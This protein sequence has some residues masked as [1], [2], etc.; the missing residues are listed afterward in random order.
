M[1][2]KHRVHIGCRQVARNA[3]ALARKM[4]SLT[5]A[6]RRMKD[7]K[8]FD[9]G[10]ENEHHI[11]TLYPEWSFD[12][13]AVVHEIEFASVNDAMRGIRN[14][15]QCPEVETV[16]STEDEEF[17]GWQARLDALANLDKM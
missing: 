11:I 12:E 1:K 14:T 6:Y 15:F 8:Q 16:E 7:W 2:T 10:T 4:P 17:Y 13:K 5:K 3:R 9:V